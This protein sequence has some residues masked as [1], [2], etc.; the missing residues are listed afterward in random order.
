MNPINQKEDKMETKK[1]YITWNT[2]LD[3]C[4]KICNNIIKDVKYYDCIV[5]VGRGGMVLSRLIAEKLKIRQ[6]HVFNI[7][8]Y[9]K[10]TSQEITTLPSFNLKLLDNKKILVVDD[11]VTTG[12]TL[13]YVC[14]K[15]IQEA[16][17][18][19]IE[20]VTEYY[21]ISV[22]NKPIIKPNYYAVEYNA[23]NTWLVFPWEWLD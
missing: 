22:N 12:K 6:I 15:I 7:H 19:M 2:L 9:V 14:G 17:E 23:N 5:S 1:I 3:D 16:K 18:P 21:N 13:E 8:S 4:K 11:V 20:T 10:N